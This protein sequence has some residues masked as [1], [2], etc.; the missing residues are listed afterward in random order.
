M[1]V[2]RTSSNRSYCSSDVLVSFLW[3]IILWAC[4]LS[5]A[6]IVAATTTTV[7]ASSLD[8]TTTCQN[9]ETEQL[10]E[11]EYFLT[12]EEEQIWLNELTAGIDDPLQ[13]HYISSQLLTTAPSW[14]FS[15]EQQQQGGE[16]ELQ[17]EQILVHIPFQR[18]EGTSQQQQQQRT[19]TTTMTAC[20]PK[21]ECV[22]LT[23]RGNLSTDQF[24]IRLDGQV[25]H[26]A[27]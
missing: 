17:V 10:L 14:W 23:V 9:N 11:I 26:V 20:I 27:D 19:T 16:S 12:A 4:C 6:I 8:T 3:M 18:R 13:L 22:T 1:M 21:T 2:S 24:Q 25:V 15:V 5:S 7:E